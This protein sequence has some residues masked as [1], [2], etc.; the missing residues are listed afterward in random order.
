MSTKTL[1]LTEVRDHFTSILRGVSQLYDRCVITKK[2]KPEAVL[3]SYEEFEGW[4]ET[5]EIMSSPK[6]AER[7]RKARTKVKE[8]DVLSFEEAFGEPL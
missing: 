8:G 2:G 6:A 1:P 4:L 7:I 3:M 5:L